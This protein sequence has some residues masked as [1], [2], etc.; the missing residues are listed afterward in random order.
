MSRTLDTELSKLTNDEILS[1][2]TTPTYVG[3]I[4]GIVGKILGLISIAAIISLCGYIIFNSS[5]ILSGKSW[6]TLSLMH[7]VNYL[8]IGDLNERITSVLEFCS[9]GWS[10][11]ILTI[12]SGYYSLRMTLASSLM[13][14]AKVL[15]FDQI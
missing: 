7:F 8:N 14:R 5:A 13:R 3:N 11:F 10:S 4:L 15:A 12:T 6:N 1:L 9:I 2:L